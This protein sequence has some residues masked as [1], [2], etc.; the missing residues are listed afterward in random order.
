MGFSTQ[1]HTKC[2]KLHQIKHNQQ[3]LIWIS[4]SFC[5]HLCFQMGFAQREALWWRSRAAGVWGV[6]GFQKERVVVSRHRSEAALQH[7][8]GRA[9]TSAALHISFQFLFPLFFYYFL[10]R[11]LSECVCVCMCLCEFYVCRR[12]THGIPFLV[13]FLI[14]NACVKFHVGK[15][16]YK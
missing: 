16:L 9:A 11:F 14:C 6:L 15:V 4:F 13:C 7:F 3:M 1:K 12:N 2:N 5:C 8:S 10:S